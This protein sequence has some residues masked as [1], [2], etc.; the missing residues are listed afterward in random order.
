LDDWPP[1]F[2][3]EL[4]EDRLSTYRQDWPSDSNRT[5]RLFS[6]F[7]ANRERPHNVP[8]DSLSS[9]EQ[10]IL[11]LAYSW[12]EYDYRWDRPKVDRLARWTI[13]LFCQLLDNHA[14]DNLTDFV[15]EWVELGVVASNYIGERLNDLS[16]IRKRTEEIL[17]DLN[18]EDFSPRLRFLELQQ[19]WLRE[20]KHWKATETVVRTG[21]LCKHRF[22]LSQKN[23]SMDPS[24]QETFAFEDVVKDVIVDTLCQL[25]FRDEDSGKDSV[26][27]DER[28]FS[29]MKHLIDQDRYLQ[30]PLVE[31]IRNDPVLVGCYLLLNE[32]MKYDYYLNELASNKDLQLPRDPD[33]VARIQA[34]TIE[35]IIRVI[36]YIVSGDES[37]LRAILRHCFKS[38]LGVNQ[39][40]RQIY[41]TCVAEKRDEVIQQLNDAISLAEEVQ[42]ALSSSRHR[43]PY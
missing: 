33:L 18:Q 38:D 43:L 19:R 16:N 14:L 3:V 28:I 32:C 10:R 24:R 9:T 26:R 13:S 37:R 4:N 11:Q 36:D 23:A 6:I 27:G 8:W 22:E 2:F 39:V 5:E 17:K 30:H 31:K 1:L 25:A 41:Y 12:T 40:L 29:S 35:R 34:F 20:P 42:M 21:E 7:Q 15:A